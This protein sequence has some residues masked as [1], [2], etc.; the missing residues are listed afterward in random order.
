MEHEVVASIHTVLE[1]FGISYDAYEA[2]MDRNF[3][4][5]LCEKDLF[6]DMFLDLGGKPRPLEREKLLATG[7][8]YTPKEICDLIVERALA[9]YEHDPGKARVADLAA[10]TG[11]LLLAL[12]DRLDLQDDAAR[13]DALSRFHAYDI[14]WEPLV[15]LVN[16]FLL[17]FDAF[18]D[19][20]AMPVHQ[21]DVLQLETDHKFDLILGNP[22]YIG[23]KG[24]KELFRSLKETPFGRQHYES[25]M[26]YHYYFLYKGYALLSER[27]V[28]GTITTNYHFT[29]DG[30]E[31]LRAFIR[32][33]ISYREILNFPEQTLFKEAQGQHNVVTIAQ[34]KRDGIPVVIHNFGQP[35][36]I[37]ASRL[38]SR[39]GYIQVY[40]EEEDYTLLET[41]EHAAT[42]HLGDFFEIHQGIV[43]GADALTARKG[44]LLDESGL[45]AGQGIFVLTDEEVRNLGL[46]DSRH[47][48]P[49]YKNSD[50][51]H[52]I[53]QPPKEKWIL[54]LDDRIALDDDSP[55]YRHLAR[56]RP[57]LE[58]RREVVNGT[59]KWHSLQWPRLESIFTGEKLVVPHRNRLNRFAYSEEPFYASAD[60]YYIVP[61]T[62][63]FDLK[64][65]AAVLN[66]RLMYYWLFNR[67]KKKGRMLELY[68]T[69]LKQI[70]VA[71]KADEEL[72]DLVT[73]YLAK[74]APEIREQIESQVYA[75]YG[76]DA[77]AR[78]HLD[79]F[80]NRMGTEDKK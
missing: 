19:H 15:I 69:P 79:S 24:H 39:T 67:G 20:L 28:M 21:M 42:F 35:F 47:L 63:M 48:K 77:S 46:K 11:N 49:F 72:S 52:F 18:P 68:S 76:L 61:R 80:Y 36:T 14:Q 25:K 73:R 9:Y 8:F 12:F 5:G 22:P 31:R 78:E 45:E 34:L 26:D 44:T 27:G 16:R 40:T 71:Y 2:F 41:I 57:I 10:G 60:V 7:S 56:F 58:M 70:P 3:A 13:S 29:A 30:A 64:I 43:S 1:R 32:E 6:I 74:P 54:Y 53:Y 55:E 23:E 37:P 62:P 38:F 4:F 33:H 50:I 65:L 66:S 17:R 51:D 75:M 59:R